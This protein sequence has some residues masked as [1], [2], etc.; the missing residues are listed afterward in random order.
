M[1]FVIQLPSHIHALLGVV[2]I[3]AMIGMIKLI[4]NVKARDVKSLKVYSSVAAVV[5]LITVLVGDFA[6]GIYSRADGAKALIKASENKWVHS[7]VME[8]K[9]HVAHYVPVLLVAVMFM[10][11]FY[12]DR[13]FDSE[14]ARKVT[15]SLVYLALVWAFITF[16]L[17]ILVLSYQPLI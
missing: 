15:L 1:G 13:L 9:E 2:M 11:F 12:K 14:S 8:F 3:I 16:I 7:I 17:G 10:V 5:S 6:Y 4:K